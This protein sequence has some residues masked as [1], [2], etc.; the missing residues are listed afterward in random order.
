MNCLNAAGS[1]KTSAC[2]L[3]WVFFPA[4]ACP[5]AV[6]ACRESARQQPR[7][8]ELEAPHVCNSSLIDSLHFH[9]GGFQDFCVC[10][11][12]LQCLWKNQLLD[13]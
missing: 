1:Q 13:F 5:Q 8:A 9:G 6:A 12:S 3:N 2:T 10:V 11:S 7:P 4:E